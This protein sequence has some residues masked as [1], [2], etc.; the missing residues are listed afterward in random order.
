MVTSREC[1]KVYPCVCL[2]RVKTQYHV[3]AHQRVDEAAHVS[4]KLIDSLVA[5]E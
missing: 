2:D 4:D 1:W 5:C 3:L